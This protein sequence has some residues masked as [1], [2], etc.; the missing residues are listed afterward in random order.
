MSY[1]YSIVNDIKLRTISFSAVLEIGDST[2]ITSYQRAFAVQREREI[3]FSSE[4]D[5]SQYPI[6]SEPIPLPQPTVP[7]NL[8]KL[9]ERPIVVNTIDII[10]T[11][12]SS[13]IHIGQTCNVFMESRVKNVRQLRPREEEVVEELTI[14]QSSS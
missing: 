7:V 12:F 6:Y 3:F 11:S 4:G 2:E 5:F 1:R 9:D 14:S 8:I 10:G 13:V